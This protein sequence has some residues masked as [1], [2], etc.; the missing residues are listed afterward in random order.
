MNALVGWHIVVLVGG[1]WLPMEKAAVAVKG[2]IQR[3]CHGES[4]AVYRERHRT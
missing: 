2:I 1:I 3:C 4:M